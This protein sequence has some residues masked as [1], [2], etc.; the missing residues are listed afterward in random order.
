[1]G[2][3]SLE[4]ALARLQGVVQPELHFQPFEL[5]PALPPEGED[6]M[7]HLARKYG[8]SREQ[9]HATRQ[10][11]KER[12]ARVGFEFGDRVRVW[13]TFDAHRL[14][15]WAGQEGKQRELKHALLRAYHTRGEN[16]GLPEVL[17][18]CALEAGLDP[19]AARQVIASDRYADEVRRLEAHY[20]ELG[21]RSVPSVIIDDRHLIEGG[22]PPEAFEQALRRIAAGETG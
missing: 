2:L 11:L 19:A 22:Q 5:N 13:N 8:A 7:E 21:I 15:H 4:I 10:V 14:L 18:R 6:A 12:G 9:L 16:P 20:Q 1:V 17:E 3:N